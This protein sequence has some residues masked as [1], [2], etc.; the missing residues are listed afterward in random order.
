[1]DEYEEDLENEVNDI[2]HQIKNQGKQINSPDITKLYPD[3]LPEQVDSFILKYTSMVVMDLA[4]AIQE[5]TR[6]TE[7]ATDII[8]LAELAKSFQGNIEILQKRKIA[9]NKNITQKEVKQ[10]D[11]DARSSQALLGD[12]GNTP[13]GIF[14]SREEIIKGMATVLLENSKTS[15]EVP[16]DVNP[17]IDV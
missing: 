12:G 6:V 3:L 7:T 11:I 8:A 4:Q 2:I 13:N 5:Q 9:D 16:V 14:A 17:P 1:M 15:V 10:M